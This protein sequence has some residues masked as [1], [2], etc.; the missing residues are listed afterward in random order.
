[1]LRSQID[2]L[3]VEAAARVSRLISPPPGFRARRPLN[4]ISATT[5]RKSPPLGRD[6]FARPISGKEN[7]ERGVANI[8]LNVCAAVQVLLHKFRGPAGQ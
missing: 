8:F 6:G 7:Q 4:G 2:E 3:A 5:L 1:M